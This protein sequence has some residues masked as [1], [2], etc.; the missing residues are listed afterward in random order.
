MTWLDR[1][2][3]AVEDALGSSARA[4]WAPQLAVFAGLPK[5]GR[6]LKR[7]AAGSDVENVKDVLVEVR[8]GLCLIGQGFE[9]SIEPHGRAGPDYGVVRGCINAVV[10][11]CRL[12]SVYED[13]DSEE[14]EKHPDMLA[15]MGDVERDVRR[16]RQK[17]EGKLRQLNCSEPS[18]LAVWVDQDCIIEGE[19]KTAMHQIAVDAASGRVTLPH[20]LVFLVYASPWVSCGR[21]QQFYT[22]SH[23]EALS[24]AMTTWRCEWESSLVGDL[25]RNALHN[26]YP[27]SSQAGATCQHVIF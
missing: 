16:I 1:A 17:A 21:Q 20:S 15:P 7:L 14:L 27:A 3:Q 25:V 5:G 4:A 11:A 8:L 13:F 22:Y 19:A 2:Y 26:Q 10:E 12:R 9:V 18:V 23:R 24:D 6:A